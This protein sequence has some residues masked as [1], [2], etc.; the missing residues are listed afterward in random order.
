L[1]K[2][3]VALCAVSFFATPGA[4]AGERP[5]QPTNMEMLESVA[6]RAVDEALE[7]APL[8][9][10]EVV[11]VRYAKDD[12]LVWV[13]GNYVAGR[14]AAMGASVYIEAAAD[15]SAAVRAGEGRVQ[16]A[17]GGSGEDETAF[18]PAAAGTSGVGEEE[19]APREGETG[20]GASGES[21]A[22]SDTTAVEGSGAG[23]EEPAAP[24]PEG[25]EEGAP[26]L[27]E[28]EAAGA[29]ESAGKEAWPGPAR[30]ESARQGA[31][32]SRQREKGGPAG[33]KP[34]SR[35]GPYAAPAGRPA[36]EKVL[37]VRVAEFEVSYPRRWR[38]SLF[39]SA[40]VE[41]AARAAI[42][43]RVLDGR[44][45][46]VVWTHS[47]RREERDV[48]SEKLLAGLEDLPG[49]TG[50]SKAARGGIGRIVEPIV[51]SGIVVGLVVLFY[52]SRT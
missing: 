44:D 41:R 5:R 42:Y 33:F 22:F 7:I 19:A 16:E 36:P 27:G 4:R 37:E 11:L 13:V 46:R 10:G 38:R 31:S 51:V 6:R 14:L 43:F 45:G 47:D 32:S 50:R 30:K 48:V 25:S 2:Y 34:S 26:S 9:K 12:P 15:T 49:Q 24:G 20:A 21:G 3:L 35:L 18:E 1:T 52:S 28:G 23:E 40:M 17:P 8:G 39:G 29:S